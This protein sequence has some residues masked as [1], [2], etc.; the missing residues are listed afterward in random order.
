MGK[1]DFQKLARQPKYVIP[2]LVLPFLLLFLVFFG[3]GSDEKNPVETPKKE[4]VV[5]KVPQPK[6]KERSKAELVAEQVKQDRLA[7]KLKADSLRAVEIAREKEAKAKATNAKRQR[8]Q[9][10]ANEINYKSQSQRSNRQVHGSAAPDEGVDLDLKRF[11]EEMEMFDQLSNRKTVKEQLDAG[12]KMDVSE[13]PL[14]YVSK[15][16]YEDNEHFTTVRDKKPASHIMA[17]VDEVVKGTSGSRVRIRLLDK[18]EVA[19]HVLEP[20][21][22]MYAFISGFSEKRVMLTIPNI[23]VED[24]IIPVGLQ[25]YDLDA[26]Q[27]LY[28]PQSNFSRFMTDAGGQMVSRTSVSLDQSSGL[29]RM[30]EMGYQSI[31]SLINSTKQAVIR[32]MRQNKAR[33]KYNTQVILVNSASR[34]SNK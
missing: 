2:L 15:V 33:I 34:K 21:F 31:E 6:T 25:V 11:K 24:E 13:P 20:G 28:V 7:N 10:I 3:W 14:Q 5:I 27:G 23:L 1:I 8:D 9:Q 17:I 4:N 18:V 19:G 32:Q 30:A 29:S 16:G 26:N 22:Y 12:P